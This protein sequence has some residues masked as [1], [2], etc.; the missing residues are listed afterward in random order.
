MPRPPKSR[1]TRNPDASPPSSVATSRLNRSSTSSPGRPAPARSNMWRR[2]SRWSIATIA[3]P[4]AGSGD[5]IECAGHGSPLRCTPPDGAAAGGRWSVMG[6]GSAAGRRPPSRR[7]PPGTDRRSRGSVSSVRLDRAVS[8][9]ATSPARPS[10]AAASAAAPLATGAARSTSSSGIPATAAL[11][12]ASRRCSRYGAPTSTGG[13][14]APQSAVG[15]LDHPAAVRRDPAEQRVQLGES[16]RRGARRGRRAWP[17][18]PGPGTACHADTAA[19]SPRPG[20]VR[21][22]LASAARRRPAPSS[23]TR[24]RQS[25]MSEPAAGLPA[26]APSRIPSTVRTTL[27]PSRQATSLSTAPSAIATTASVVPIDRTRRP[28][29]RALADPGGDGVVMTGD[30]HRGIRI[31]QPTEG[32]DGVRA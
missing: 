20:R 14:P 16:G 22:S 26:S 13:A 15:G 25:S 27:M 32:G 21:G 11:R 29:E 23:S 5:R 18:R 28:R 10:L 1:S 6:C 8:G 9:R 17:T 2:L 31:D 12:P 7:S 4:P 19:R 3:R 24:A 30:V